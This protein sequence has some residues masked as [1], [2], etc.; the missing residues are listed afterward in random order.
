MGSCFRKSQKLPEELSEYEKNLIE[1]NDNLNKV[2][3]DEF[4]CLNCGKVPEIIN[5]HFDNGKIE[6]LCETCGTFEIS[7]SSY[8]SKINNS[9]YNYYNIN[10]DE[11]GRNSENEICNYCY[12]C[13]KNFCDSHK[14]RHLIHK[15][16]KINEKKNGCFKHEGE[17]FIEFC[18]DCKENVCKKCSKFHLNHKLINLNDLFSE[19]KKYSKVIIKKNRELSNI[20]RFNET[21]RETYELYQDN[22]FHLKSLINI[23]KSIKKENYRSSEQ[24]QFFNELNKYGLNEY[25]INKN[26]KNNNNTKNNIDLAIS[27]LKKKDIYLLREEEDICLYKKNL[28]C[29]DF[30]FISLITFNQLKE[31]DVSHN[32][33]KNI[34]PL[35]DMFL[36][37]LE[38]LNM[39]FNLIENIE[40]ITK[41]TSPEIKEIFLNNNKIKDFNEFSETDFKNLDILRI[42]NNEGSQNYKKLEN[43]YPNII[44]YD[45]EVFES[46]KR[47]YSVFKLKIDTENLDLSNRN[48]LSS[49]I[50]RDIYINFNDKGKMNKIKKL[51]LRN[52]NISDF[53]RLAKISLPRLIELDL[54]MNKI[55]NLDFLLKMKLN[56]LENLFL[57]NNQINNIFVLSKI[58]CP[59][60]K[61]INLKKNNFDPNDPNNKKILEDFKN[62]HLESELEFKLE[63]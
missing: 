40:P 55:N 22:Y 33:I 46:F 36:P 7:I 39:S 57:Y 42:D 48:K 16:I 50:L 15:T 25:E 26:K 63:F 54:S 58:K 8:I 4:F 18:E 59:K 3:K 56:I 60:L 51:K 21:I 43:K 29:K 10:C 11:C 45:R 13:N 12:T 6:F 38:I 44:I 14:M 17:K 37:F 31:I 52:N 19:F 62:K 30:K 34:E 24:I 35:N 28:K 1:R 9:K 20:V 32:E 49:H 5:S 2:P 53:S 47:K 61:K 27:E 41:L 23:G